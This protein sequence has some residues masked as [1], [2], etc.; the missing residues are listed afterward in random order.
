[1]VILYVYSI[2]GTYTTTFATTFPKL[3]NEHLPEHLQ[4]HLYEHHAVPVELAISCVRGAA[5]AAARQRKA[6]SQTCS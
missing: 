6:Y 5:A 1:M 2:H 3:F 4:Q